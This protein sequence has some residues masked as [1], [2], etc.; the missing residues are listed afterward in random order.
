MSEHR[1]YSSRR[2][3]PLHG[4]CEFWPECDCA[5]QMG[6][7]EPLFSLIKRMADERSPIPTPD[8]V[9]AVEVK[10][11][12]VLSCISRNCPT[13]LYRRQAAIELMKPFY[14][15]QRRKDVCR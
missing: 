3:N 15:R 14:D 9:E 10:L 11:Y 6:K 8:E 12:M 2:S 4:R 7:G 13:E 5:R 1:S